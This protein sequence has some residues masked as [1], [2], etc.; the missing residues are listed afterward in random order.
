MNAPHKPRA[1]SGANWISA[2]NPTSADSL[3]SANWGTTELTILLIPG[4]SQLCL[5][6]LIEPLRLTNSLVGHSVFKWRLVSFDGKPVECASGILVG[7]SGSL[8]AGEMTLEP[9]TSLVICASEGVENQGKPALRSFLRRCSRAKVAIYALGTA[10]WLL[11]DAAILRDARCTIHWARMA[12]LSETFENLTVDDALFVRDGHIV[13]CAGD[14]AAFD[15]AIDLVREKGGGELANYLCQYVTADR[16]REG[17]HCQSVPPELRY[18]GAGR[19]LLPIVKLMERNLEDPLSLQE[20]SR[21]VALSRRQIERLFIGHLSTTPSQYYFS[22]RLAKA[23]QLIE[24][25]DMPMMDIA[26]ACGFVTSSHFS[27]MFRDRFG[28][29][30][31]EFRVSLRLAR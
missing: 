3:I 25:T 9:R 21:R 31:S 14:F 2:F 12:A 24:L 15:L 23:R 18:G 7:V 5:S 19:R 20:I 22:L 4:F 27:K 30:P 8:L 1:F 29:A 28:Q 10:A 17:T 13:T 6:S 11:A 26:I 16:W